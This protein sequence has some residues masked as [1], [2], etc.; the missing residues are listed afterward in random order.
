MSILVKRYTRQLYKSYQIWNN[1]MI[2]YR[3]YIHQLQLIMCINDAGYVTDL[4]TSLTSNYLEQFQLE[5]EW[6]I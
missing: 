5:N 1:R 2:L 6:K 3:L 4:K